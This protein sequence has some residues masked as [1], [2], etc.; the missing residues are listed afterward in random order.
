MTEPLAPIEP[1]NHFLAARSTRSSR[2]HRP[3]AP[4]SAACHTA[5]DAGQ[6][7][8][9]RNAEVRQ[10][11]SNRL[12]TPCPEGQPRQQAPVITAQ[13]GPSGRV[14][15][16]FPTPGD[17]GATSGANRAAKSLPNPCIL[18]C[19]RQPKSGVR[20]PPSTASSEAVS[21]G[22][23]PSPLSWPLNGT[24]GTRVRYGGVLRGFGHRLRLGRHAAELS[25]L[26]DHLTAH[27]P[28]L[29]ML[30]APRPV[31]YDPTGPQAAVRLG[32]GDGG[33]RAGER[34]EAGLPAVAGG[35]TGPAPL[36]HSETKGRSPLRTPLYGAGPGLSS[37]WGF[38]PV[39]PPA[40]GTRPTAP[41]G[42]GHRRC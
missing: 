4:D 35:G 21:P 16:R 28:V 37:E 14:R 15:P 36:P 18:A 27:G 5:P 29:E 10:S 17:G 26:A 2:L 38:S 40:R 24:P 42:C 1:P 8:K 41:S 34:Q 20:S 32:P 11:G 6:C 23:A 9:L 25:A 30:T 12:R 33:D 31:I 19:P 7:G 22:A 3:A 39:G 13:R